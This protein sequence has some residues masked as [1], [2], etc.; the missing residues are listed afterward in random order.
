MPALCAFN[1]ME[2]EMIRLLVRLLVL[3]GIFAL[4]AKR[5]QPTRNQRDGT[6]V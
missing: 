5:R 1:N 2:D 4:V 6:T 3:S